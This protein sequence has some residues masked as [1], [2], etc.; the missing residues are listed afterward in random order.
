MR[1]DLAS[2]NAEQLASATASPRVRESASPG[3]RTKAFQVIETAHDGLGFAHRGRL[4]V[5]KAGK[6]VIVRPRWPS[7]TVAA[8]RRQ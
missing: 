1:A 5:I 7:W 2:L 4:R 8:I 3:Q 6:G